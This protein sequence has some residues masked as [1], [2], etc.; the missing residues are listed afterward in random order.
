MRVN[1]FLVGTAIGMI[2][3]FTACNIAFHHP[4]RRQVLVADNIVVDETPQTAVTYPWRRQNIALEEVQTF[5]SFNTDTPVPLSALSQSQRGAINGKLR[6]LK[7][8]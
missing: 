1:R 3:G 8:F 4:D 5:K 7:V 6:N 2:I